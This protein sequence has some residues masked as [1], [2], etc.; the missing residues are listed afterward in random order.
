MPKGL[1]HFDRHEEKV[2]LES[3]LTPRDVEDIVEIFKTPLTG[4]TIGTIQRQIID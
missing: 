1:R 4:S 3:K 2:D